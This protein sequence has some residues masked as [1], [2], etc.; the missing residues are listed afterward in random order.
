MEGVYLRYTKK[1]D[2]YAIIDPD[3]VMPEK[4][5]G[6]FNEFGEYI[7]DNALIALRYYPYADDK[8]KKALTMFSDAL[9]R[10]LTI[11]FSVEDFKKCKKNRDLKRYDEL[12]SLGKRLVQIQEAMY[13]IKA[14]K[15]KPELRKSKEVSKKK[16]KSI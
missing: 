1:N 15:S 6:A 16:S 9:F 12:P 10:Q 7:I 5:G 8:S 13:Y 11:R 2:Q 3:G 14:V 4:I